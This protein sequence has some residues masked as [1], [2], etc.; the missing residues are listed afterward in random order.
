MLASRI[1]PQAVPS[2]QYLLSS[3]EEMTPKLH[4]NWAGKGLHQAYSNYALAH[5]CTL[6]PNMQA[7]TYVRNIGRPLK[8]T[9]AMIVEDGD[10][11]GLL[12][13]GAIGELCF[14]GDQ[15]GRCLPDYEPSVTGRFADHLDL[16]RIYRTGDF[17]RLLPD[18]T[19]ILSRSSGLAQS[20]APSIDLDG[21]DRAL[22]SLK[23]TQESVSMIL[24]EP[25]LRQRRLAV[26]WVPSTKCSDSVQIEE[27]TN[28][29]FKELTKKLPSSSLP[30][31]LVLVDAISLTMSYKTDHFMLRQRLE[32][33]TT[34][35]LAMFSPKLNDTGDCFTE[36]EKTISAA[37]SAVTGTDQISI[38]KHTSFYRLG[39]DSLSAISFSRKLQESGCGRLSVSTILR[40][41]SIAQLAAVI[42]ATTDEHQPEQAVVPTPPMVFDEN[43]THQVEDEFKAAA[44]TVQ[45]IYPCT[46]LQEAMLAAESGGHTAYFNHLLLLV[47]T[48]A[49]DMRAAWAKMMQRQGILRTCFTQ[50]NDKGFAYAQVVLD[51]SI[52]PWSHIETPSSE[53][54]NVI[55]ESK[56]KFEGLSPVNGQLPYSLTLITDSTA[57]KTH[58]LLSIHHALYDGEGIA[59]LLHEL[60]LLLS[61]KELPENAPFHNFINYMTSVDYGSSDEYWDQYLSGVSPTLLPTPEPAANADVSTSQQIH[62]SLNGSFVSFKQQC[63]DLSVTPLNIFHAAWFRLLSLYT[64]SSDVCFGNV[65][66]CRTVPLDDADRIVGP[67]FNT[68]P[69]RIKS[70]STATNGDIMKL[71]QKSNNNILPHQ[72]SPLRRIQRRVLGDGSRLF[73]TLVIFQNRNIDLDPNVWELL[74][75]EGNMGF[76]LICEIVPDESADNIQICLHFQVSYISQAVAENIARDFVALVGHITQYPSAQASDKRLLG[77]DIGRVFEQKV[78]QTPNSVQFLT[79]S[80]PKR[81]WSYQEEIVRDLICKFSDVDSDNVFQ[82]TTIFQLGL[83]SIN[84]VQVSAKLRGLGYK[85][86]SGDIL[87]VCHIPG[88]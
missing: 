35:E 44:M 49:E 73:D 36:L 48:D 82:D 51:T 74:Q 62:T 21:V 18:G 20:Y 15:I 83:D 86:S 80:R 69:I 5:A 7:S 42:L 58:L 70:S 26:F 54:E 47:H 4:R 59:R 22:M 37:L 45:N 14:G 65:F 31:L 46:P 79:K 19:L 40:Y 28:D 53:I 55:K 12:P 85:I 75:D 9:S 76:P 17:G 10:S 6:C 23:M 57:H 41:S 63:K 30:S 11:L 39:L 38:R 8:N 24:D 1:D 77:A 2:V 50:T 78:P 43:F 67:C 52:L 87:E 27:A 32:Q 56:S 3:G 64:D 25:T 72:L 88:A 29:L 68:L 84:A 60:Q 13:R 16:G 71:S 34:K 81:P 33:L 61:G 66:S